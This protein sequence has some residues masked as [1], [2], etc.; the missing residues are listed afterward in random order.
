MRRKV[1]E[2]DQALILSSN[3][4]NR[5]MSSSKSQNKSQR[6]QYDPQQDMQEKREVRKGY[7]ALIAES[8]GQ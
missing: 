1:F 2:L 7:R 6:S 4:T 5:K 8:E 3:Q